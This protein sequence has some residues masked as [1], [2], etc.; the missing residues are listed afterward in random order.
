[1]EDLADAEDVFA[2]A[3]RRAG[4]LQVATLRELFEA[5]GTLASGIRPRGDRLAIL[6]N[7]GGAAILAADAVERHGGRLAELSDAT[8]ARLSGVLP[9]NWRQGDPV[10]MLREA[11]D[12]RYADAL[13]ALLDDDGQDAVLVMNCPTAIADGVEA[14]RATIRTLDATRNRPVVT[15][16]LG[17]R[18]A[19]D[20]RRLFAERG[21]P[22]YDTPDEAVRAFMQLVNYRHNQDMLMETPPA[23]VAERVDREAAAAVIAGALGAGRPVLSAPEAFAFL[24]AYGIP[25]VSYTHLTL[26]TTPYV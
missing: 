21:V 23:L 2:A 7:G 17:E 19:R 4:M 12:A 11:D 16:W 22:T 13:S 3:C 10:D 25:T 1:M 5:V 18:A 26:P 24:S 6:T 9:K 8:R 15:C 14:A 20:S